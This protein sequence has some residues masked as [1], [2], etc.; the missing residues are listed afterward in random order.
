MT[1]I[2]ILRM[3]LE[4]HMVGGNKKVELENNQGFM[5]HCQNLES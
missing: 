3:L 5:F 1:R 4:Y 2:K